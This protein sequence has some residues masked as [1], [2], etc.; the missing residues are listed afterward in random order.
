MIVCV[1]PAK[2]G[3]TRLENKNMTLINGKPMLYYTVLAA[4]ES[5]L[6]NKVYVSTDAVDI[7]DFARTMGTEVIHRPKR[8]T[9][10]TP[11]TDVYQHA[12]KQINDSSVSYVVGLQPDHPDRT[13]DLD[14]ALRWMM[15][16]GYDDMF[17]V[18][19]SGQ[20]N[21]SLRIIRADVLRG[22]HT[23][24]TGTIQDDCTNVHTKRDLLKAERKIRGLSGI[25]KVGKR[26]V[27]GD[28]PA[29]IVAEG[30]NNH[31]GSV[32]IARKMID[33]AS[34]AGA[35]AI[36]FQTFK[37]EHL[38]TRDAP[39]FWKMPGVKTQFEFYRSIDRFGPD[40]YRILL[41]YARDRGIIC[42]STPFDRE[43]ATMLNELGADLFKIASCDV[44]DLRLIRHVAGFHKP[45]I[46]STGASE[47]SELRRAVD[48][49]YEAGNFQVGLLVCTLSY[50]TQIADANLRRILTLKA[51]FPEAV[52]GLSDH[53]EPDDGMVLPA[54]AVSLGARI[55]EKHFTLD[56]TMPGIGHA[57]ASNPDHIRHLVTAVRVA[58]RA[59]GSSE[60]RVYESEKLARQSA[61]RSLVAQ[62]N[63]HAGEVI[64]DDMIGVKRPGGGIAADAIDQV[65]G[66]IALCDIP[67]DALLRFEYLQSSEVL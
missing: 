18:D 44:P 3:S 56:R 14:D 51:E 49:A 34:E 17:S 8:L 60:V 62:R 32:E 13:V 30:A 26:R 47:L 61:R 16:K 15:Q 45:M 5:R 65:V 7:A 58:E 42:F 11:V 63:I 19:I 59:L 39:I 43:C 55:I 23:V 46:I 40:E 21:G 1:I 20:K 67:Q 37:A 33:A 41:A 2:G 25:L 24:L 31:Q 35:D 57:F 22:R 50:P 4:C 10:D 29:F 54:V 53:T 9:G 36:K 28:A 64:R 52:I 48:A 66:R 27:G 6:I 12:L 38:V